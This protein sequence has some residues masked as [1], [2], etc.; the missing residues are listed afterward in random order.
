ME[1]AEIQKTKVA[2][3]IQKNDGVSRAQVVD[4]LSISTES[5]KKAEWV[6]MLK[7][8]PDIRPEKIERAIEA[9]PTSLELA[10]II[11]NEL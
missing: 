6:E 4:R 3:Q 5:E 8:M 9:D 2:G 11:L 10:Q 1:I 7:E